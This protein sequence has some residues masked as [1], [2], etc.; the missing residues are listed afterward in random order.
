MT[1]YHFCFDLNNF[2]YIHQN[3]L[4]DA[5]WTWQRTAIVSLFLFTAGVG[6]AIAV[7]R[8]Q[9]WPRFWRRWAQVAGCAVLVSVG[10]WFMFPKSYIHFGVLH[11]LAVMLIVARLTAGWGGWL[12]LLGL[13][14]ITLPS[15]ANYVHAMLGSAAFSSYF[16]GRALNW[17]GWV[18]RKPF[19]EDYV[20]VFPWLGVLWWGV[21]AGRWALQ[22][23]PGW[24]A[25]PA[26]AALRPL[27]ALGRWSLSYYMLHQPVMIGALMLIAALK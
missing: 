13:L 8:G 2:G 21:A 18:S 22:H 15:I 24:L 9:G 6:Q 14:A 12:W 25:S 7:H 20:P 16:D 1:V 23:R 17:L 26:A 5:L 19:T 4:G 3:F 10:S 27:V 11:G